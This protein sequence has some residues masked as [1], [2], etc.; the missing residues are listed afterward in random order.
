[1]LAR[2][3]VIRSLWVSFR[4]FMDCFSTGSRLGFSAWLVM[5]GTESA[6]LFVPTDASSRTSSS[7]LIPLASL[8]LFLESSFFSVCSRALAPPFTRFTFLGLFMPFL[9]LYL[10]PKACFLMLLYSSAFLTSMSCL[11]LTSSGDSYRSP[12]LFM[13]SAA[14]WLGRK[15]FITS[16]LL[17]AKH[18]VFSVAMAL[19]WRVSKPR[20]VSSPKWSPIFRSRMCR[21]TVLSCVTTV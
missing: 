15:N 3:I 12:T 16:D 19:Y 9:L 2:I 21:A 20:A 7:T 13:S 1:M 14:T 18:S 5:L 17:M 6:R 11:S 4:T 8:S 10:S